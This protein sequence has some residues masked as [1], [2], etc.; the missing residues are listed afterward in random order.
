MKITELLGKKLLFF[1]GAMGTQL[2]L[3]GLAPGEL[4]ELWNQ[5]N[6]NAV[7]DIHCAYLAAGCDVV[8]ANTFG[9]NGL[10]LCDPVAT[11]DAVVT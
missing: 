5:T 9:A 7:L 6:P 8:L 10:K 11:V 4:P 1:D 2:Q 3:R